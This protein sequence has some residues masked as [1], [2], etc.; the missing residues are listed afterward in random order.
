MRRA[1]VLFGGGLLVVAALA[2][3]G[4]RPGGPA[5]RPVSAVQLPSTVAVYPQG[6][7][8]ASPAP[9]TGM[10]H[11]RAPNPGSLRNAPGRQAAYDA[12][13]KPGEFVTPPNVSIE[14]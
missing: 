14:H 5:P 13:A 10:S 2:G 12:E 9:A 11:A 3:L 8:H 4:W 1:A 7:V 6:V